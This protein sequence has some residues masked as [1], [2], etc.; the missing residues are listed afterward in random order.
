MTSSAGVLTYITPSPGASPVAVTRQSQIV[1]SFV[2]EFTLCELPPLEFFPISRMPPAS[3]TPLPS[4]ISAAPY[5]N[6]SIS[7]WPG[8]GTCTTIYSPTI[9]MVCATT[10]TALAEKYTITNCAQDLTFSTE[11]GAVLVTPTPTPVALPSPISVSL[12]NSSVG[13]VAGGSQGTAALPPAPGSNTTVAQ[14]T[15]LMRRQA[16]DSAS[17]TITPGPSIELLTTYY[18]AP[19]QQLTAGEAPTDVDLKVCR[20]FALNDTTECIREYQHWTTSLVT[21]S[22]TS[23][24][25]VNISTT[26]HGRSQIIVETFVANVTEMLTTFSMSTTMELEYQTEWTTTHSTTREIGAGSTSTGPTVYETLT[27]AH[28]SST[29]MRAADDRQANV[30]R[31]NDYKL[32]DDPLDQHHLCGYDYRYNGKRRGASDWCSDYTGACYYV[33]CLFLT[34]DRFE[35]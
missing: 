18:L 33:S 4:G 6:Y 24:T 29:A 2:P 5:Q 23:T 16:T 26:I 9:T 32:D 3:R 27:V 14:G 31:S 15:G 30:S 22:R 28:P 10:L 1:G 21:A 11:Y 20:T 19:W 35:S 34:V 13:P 7:T 8:N 12:Q 17:A 25:S